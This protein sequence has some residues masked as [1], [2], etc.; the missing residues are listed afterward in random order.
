MK[1][2]ESLDIVHSNL[3]T[4]NVLINNAKILKITDFGKQG[5]GVYKSRVGEVTVVNY[6]W[7]APELFINGSYS[8]KSDVW[9]FAVVLWEIATFGMTYE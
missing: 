6:R 5:T 2:L 9:A 8:S 1:Y 3:T 4:K 7:A